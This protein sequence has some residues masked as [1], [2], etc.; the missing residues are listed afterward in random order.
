MGGGTGIA[1]QNVFLGADTPY[2]VEFGSS[3]VG[4]GRSRREGYETTSCVLSFLLADTSRYFKR[5]RVVLDGIT[6][7]QVGLSKI[8]VN[9][10]G[11]DPMQKQG[12]S[13]L[14]IQF[15]NIFPIPI[16]CVF[17]F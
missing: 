10:M 4:I 13:S 12:F 1:Q 6:T 5:E 14:S 7:L 9:L 16:F 2:N 15:L 11:W 3:E 8:V 17:Y